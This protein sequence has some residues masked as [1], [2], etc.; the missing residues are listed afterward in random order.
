MKT[1]TQ[2]FEE[3]LDAYDGYATDRIMA[4]ST[5][6]DCE[7]R[8]ERH[9][10]DLRKYRDEF[11][12]ACRLSAPL[13]GTGSGTVV[14]SY[15]GPPPTLGA[16]ILQAPQHSPGDHLFRPADALSPTLKEALEAGPDR[17]I[18]VESVIERSERLAERHTRDDGSSR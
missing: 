12:E 11:R 14:L 8:L 9:L 16:E 4:T 6:D 18:E 2:I 1:P 10:A 17:N 7:A 3:L 13:V 5:A 15:D